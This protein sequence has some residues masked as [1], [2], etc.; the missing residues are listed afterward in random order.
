MRFFPGSFVV[1]ILASLLTQTVLSQQPTQSLAPSVATNPTVTLSFVILLH[2]TDLRALNTDSSNAFT[3]DMQQEFTRI[4]SVQRG[5]VAV[6]PER[7]NSVD[8]IHIRCT[9]LRTR[10]NITLNDIYTYTAEDS[11]KKNILNSYVRWAQASKVTVAYSTRVGK[12]LVMFGDNV[13]KQVYGYESGDSEQKTQQT[14]SASHTSSS[15][16]ATLITMMMAVMVL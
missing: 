3:E 15:I 9:V 16:L 13:W 4:C 1:A 12:T 7:Y 6:V 2:N 5:Y 11:F 14:S 8:G 10:V